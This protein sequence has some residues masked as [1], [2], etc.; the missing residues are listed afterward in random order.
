MAEG[1][2]PGGVRA[3]T[4]L[5]SAMIDVTAAVPFGRCR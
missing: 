1:I 4:V 3:S 2:L 5:L